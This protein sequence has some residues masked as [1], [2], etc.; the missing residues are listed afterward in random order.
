MRDHGGNIDGARS[1]FGGAPE[2]WI[3]LSTGINRVPYPIPALSPDAW[4]ALPTQAALA[5]LVDAAKRTYRCETNIL[6]VA[7]AQAAIQLIPRLFQI[8]HARV[9]SPTYNEHAA[10]LLGA[11]WTVEEVDTVDGLVGADLAILVN[12][13]NPDGRET[14]PQ[15]LVDLAQKVGHLVVDESFADARPDLSVVPFMTGVDNLFVLRSFG[16]FYGLAGLRLGFVLGSADSIATLSAMSGPWPVSGVAIEIGRKALLDDTWA[17]DTVARLRQEVSQ[18]DRMATAAG[19]T[20]IGGTELFRLYDTPNAQD[21]QSKLA[22]NHIWSRIFPW[23][24]GLIRLGLP[25]TVQEW[26]RLRE[27]M[28]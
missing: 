15:R 12:P 25:G 14:S 5:S 27:A 16:K 22:Q 10:C 2:D 18:I 1:L 17:Q 21:A 8:G 4:Q 28:S 6:P 24:H 9:L 23:S 11:G 26:T 13:N 7:G 3:D 19:W 20:V